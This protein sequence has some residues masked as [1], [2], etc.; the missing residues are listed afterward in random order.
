MT[1]DITAAHSDLSLLLMDS[2]PPSFAFIISTTIANMK[3]SEF[4]SDRLD[5]AKKKLYLSLRKFR[6]RWEA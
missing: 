4:Q 2:L 3:Y 6:Q 1:E 5:F